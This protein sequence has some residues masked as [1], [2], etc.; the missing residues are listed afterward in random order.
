VVRDFFGV[1]L[2]PGKGKL[3]STYD[4][5]NKDPLRSFEGDPLNVE[6]R[7]ADSAQTAE[8]I[9]ESLKPS[10][11]GPDFRVAVACLYAGDIDRNEY[12]VS[13]INRSERT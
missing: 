8:E 12:D 9:Y 13:I 1:T 6:I 5:V 11:A 2:L 3:I 7:G 4:G 10:G